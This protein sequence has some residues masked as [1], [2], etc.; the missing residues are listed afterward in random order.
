MNNVATGDVNLEG[1]RTYIDG[2]MQRYRLLFSVNGGAFAIVALVVKNTTGRIDLQ[3]V[4]V[5]GLTMEAIAL[6]AISF[7]MLMTL[8][9][10]FFGQ[11]MKK[12]VVGRFG[13]TDE[14]KAILLLI[15]ALIITAW[16]F[17]AQLRKDLLALPVLAGVAWLIIH[18]IRS[19]RAV[20]SA[21]RQAPIC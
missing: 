16:T 17:A 1:L 19:K 20:E 4:Q 2:K 11:M 8:D 15:A 10:W 5:G 12:Q 21:N 13:F 3:S 18:S 6:G 7:T 9:I 14:G